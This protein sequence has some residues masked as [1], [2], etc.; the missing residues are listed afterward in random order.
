MVSWQD[1]TG[2]VCPLGL[3]PYLLPHRFEERE[4][5]PRR[6]RLPLR[7]HLGAPSVPVVREGD[8]VAAGQLV[9]EIA[10]G[11]LGSRIFTPLA[12]TVR[13]VAGG[14]IVVEVS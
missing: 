8:R 1:G 13:A 14:E 12:G 7:Q 3:E 9:A 4:V 6:L 10:E 2:S 5:R 11:Q